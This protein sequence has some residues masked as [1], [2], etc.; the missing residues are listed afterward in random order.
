MTKKKFFEFIKKNSFYFIV[1]FCS[2]IFSSLS[3]FLL[4]VFIARNFSPE[5]FGSFSSTIYIATMF[6]AF[7]ILG[8]DGFLI[9]VYSREKNFFYSF[10]PKIFTLIFIS[11]I[12]F[13]FIYL[14][15]AIF[16]SSSDFT[17]KL[18]IFFIVFIVSNALIDLL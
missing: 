4:N 16:S 15:I 6:S 18:M 13:I 9:N 10:L 14:L 12:I 2:L 8:F 7:I 5:I 17:R 1:I 11:F 3:T